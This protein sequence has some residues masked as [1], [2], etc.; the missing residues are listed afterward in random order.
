MAPST[1][2]EPAFSS[3]PKM[4]EDKIWYLLKTNFE[5]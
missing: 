4:A 2:F 3:N 1:G 5:L